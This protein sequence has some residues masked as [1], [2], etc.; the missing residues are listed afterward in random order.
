MP[1]LMTHFQCVPIITPRSSTCVALYFDLSS[2]LFF[3]FRF[4]L[5]PYEWQFE[6]F[7]LN[8]NSA[9]R[10][11]WGGFVND[12]AIVCHCWSEHQSEPFIFNGVM[13]WNST[14]VLNL[15]TSLFNDLFHIRFVHRFVSVLFGSVFGLKTR[16]MNRVYRTERSIKGVQRKFT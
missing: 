11:W 2:S 15:S 4:K 5:S 6:L 7:E 10:Q 13:W 8:I 16:L 12:K 3:C 1:W 14:I 9:H